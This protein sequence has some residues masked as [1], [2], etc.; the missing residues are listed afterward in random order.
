MIILYY[1]DDS[2]GFHG[3]EVDCV[4]ELMGLLAG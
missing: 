3:I 1:F 4:R 2:M